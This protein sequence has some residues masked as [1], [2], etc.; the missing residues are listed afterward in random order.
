MRKVPLVVQFPYAHQLMGFVFY[1]ILMASA[2]PVRKGLQ[3]ILE[4]L[5]HEHEILWVGLTGS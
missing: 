4:Q 3:E 5:N 2:E 1:A